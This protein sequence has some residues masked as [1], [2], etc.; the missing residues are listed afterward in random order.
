MA[1]FGSQG[2]VRFLT[3]RGVDLVEKTSKYIDY[4]VELEANVLKK[5]KSCPQL[6]QHYAKYVNLKQVTRKGVTTKKLI[7]RKIQSE[8]S[9]HKFIVKNLESGRP[10]AVD[11]IQNI[12]CMTLCACEMLR[13]KL[14]IVHN[15]LHT[16]NVL[17]TPTDAAVIEYKF[18]N[19][20]YKYR[21]YGFFPVIIDFGYAY[22]QGERVLAPPLS[23][24]IGYDTCGEDKLA[25][26][27]ILLK[28]VA[29]LLD[30]PTEFSDKVGQIFLPTVLTNR[31]SFPDGYFTSMTKEIMET[32]SASLQDTNGVFVY[33]STDAEDMINL[34]LA[35]WVPHGSAVDSCMNDN[36]SEDI[37]SPAIKAFADFK[38][39]A[40]ACRKFKPVGA[41]RQLAMIKDWL[42]MPTAQLIIKYG[43]EINRVISTCRRLLDTFDPIQMEILAINKNLR[44]AE[45]NKLSVSTTLDVL[46][47]LSTVD[48]SLM[49]DMSF[50]DDD[51][52]SKILSHDLIK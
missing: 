6:A 30:S 51:I 5:I 42:S 40:T 26:A 13:L 44:E 3:V 48:E 4:T 11:V 28:S 46:D 25:D 1:L 21:T 9:F 20:I 8:Y 41:K 50:G 34:F 10:N 14:G 29:R 31:G 12:A 2:V 43:Q 49:A 24:D 47:L 17:I 22:V 18:A 27:R 19:K 15:D 37:Y 35:Q 52:D 33:D 39:A 23:M 36:K 16:S 7:Y 38:L 32:V 45:Y